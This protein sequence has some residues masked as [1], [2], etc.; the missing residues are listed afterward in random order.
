M[1]TYVYVT[2]Y[3][4]DACLNEISQRLGTDWRHLAN[5]LRISVSDERKHRSELALLQAWRDRHLD[6]PSE[7]LDRL[8]RA[9]ATIRRT[10]LLK[11]LEFYVRDMRRHGSAQEGPKLVSTV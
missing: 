1:L 4:P 6:R 8:R 10:D 5:Q 3:L 9:L 7:A 11:I 2:D